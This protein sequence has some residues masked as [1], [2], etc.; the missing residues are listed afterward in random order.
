MATA[1]R[2]FDAPPLRAFG[3]QYGPLLGSLLGLCLTT[4]RLAETF[5]GALVDAAVSCIVLTGIYAA[6]PGRKSAAIGLTL[7]FFALASHRVMTRHDLDALHALHYLFLLAILLYAT[8]TILRAVAR[9]C[10]VTV[11]TIKGAVCVYLLIGVTWLYIFVLIDSFSPGSFRLD[12]SPEGRVPEWQRLPQLLYLSFSTLTT[13]GYGDIIPLS[14]PARTACYLE[15]AVG[16]VYL[17]VLIARL[18]GMHI[19]QPPPA[20]PARPEGR[21]HS[22]ERDM[23]GVDPGASALADRGLGPTEIPI[24]PQERTPRKLD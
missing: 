11:D 1:T 3:G 18:V 4:P 16:Q 22:A 10:V 15:A 5:H 14:G 2:R 6:A 21:E 24:G 12:P 23:R 17:T 9:D 7:A 19:S 8:L 20:E 13:L